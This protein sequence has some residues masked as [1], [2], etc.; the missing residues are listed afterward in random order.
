M[1][2]SISKHKGR[3]HIKEPDREYEGLC[4][5]VIP[6]LT[7]DRVGEDDANDHEGGQVGAQTRK[8]LA[9]QL[10]HPAH[11]DHNR[12]HY[13]LPELRRADEVAAQRAHIAEH[14]GHQVAHD[15]E[16]ADH[17]PHPVDAHPDVDD[18]DGLGVELLGARGEARVGT[19]E[20]RSPVLVVLVGKPH[21][22]LVEEDHRED[23]GGTRQ[24]KES[25]NLNIIIYFCVF[26][27]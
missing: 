20:G 2:T 5:D 1:L 13:E 27:M 4:L 24:K 14:L 10:L 8:L 16:V 25:I 9:V 3:E 18:D 15:D 19:L 7:P 6:H 22:D 26:L 17:V 23:G 12:K 11:R 21:A